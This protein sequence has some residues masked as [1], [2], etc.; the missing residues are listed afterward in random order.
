MIDINDTKFSWSNN[1]DFKISDSLLY[2]KDNNLVLDG[3]I[4]IEIFNINEIYKFLKSPRN[5]RKEIEK[6]K[7]N[8]AYNF[9]QK[10]TTL[11]NI[12]I[13]GLV[14]QQVN[15]ILNE[16]ISKDSL[17]QNRVY[18]KSLINKALKSYAG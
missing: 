1:V 6:I 16:I 14:N 18:L 5:H 12:E 17:L 11:N 7:L 4:E 2:V 3:N 10:V 9:D 13:D 8:F 15:Q